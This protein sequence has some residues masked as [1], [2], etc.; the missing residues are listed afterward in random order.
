MSNRRN[1][2]NGILT[3]SAHK[4][5]SKT[6]TIAAVYITIARPKHIH[7]NTCREAWSQ[8]T[9]HL[10]KHYFNYSEMSTP[11]TK[12]MLHL[13]YLKAAPF[14]DHG[15][16]ST[17]SYRFLKC[18]LTPHLLPSSW[19]CQYHPSQR[20][21]AERHLPPKLLPAPIQTATRTGLQVR[22]GKFVIILRIFCLRRKTRSHSHIP[23]RHANLTGAKN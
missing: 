13:M 8:L 7:K 22:Q 14:Y 11:T 19:I 3:H 10:H 9:G 23:F 1:S 2:Y 17:Q 15:Q 16:V 4:S 21:V 6:A 5:C 18:H 12:F 20:I